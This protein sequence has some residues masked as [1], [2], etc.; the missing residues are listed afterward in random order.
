MKLEQIYRT[1]VE[2]GISKDPRGKEG[3]EQVLEDARKEYEGLKGKEKKRFDRE[4]LENPFP[5]TRILYGDPEMEIASVIAGVDVEAPELLL[6]DRLREKGIRIDLCIAHH[7][8]GRA[9]AGLSEVMSLQADVWADL[10]VPVNIGDALISER[11]AEVRRAFLPQNHQRPVDTARLLDIPFMC[12]HTPA[13][14][15]VTD[16]LS[17]A[18]KR[19]KPRLVVDVI[20]ELLKQPEYEAAA[21]RGLGPTVIAGEARK[22]AGELFVDMT[23]GTELPTSAIEKLADA[24][25]G[26]MICMHMSD[27]LKKEAEKYHINVVVA[28][29]IASDNIGLN[30]LL[31]RLE[32]KG[33]KIHAFS[34]LD[35]VSRLKR[36]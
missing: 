19:A 34:G 23:G 7:P 35:R 1:A 30:L 29:H 25:V 36:K 31:D 22:R 24:G 4:R 15:L 11:M 28:G 32:A 8:E 2:L 10:G 17:R 27:K 26:T 5:D 16:M 21:G 9:L 12:V 14:N 13:D 20:E 18:L 3:V 6:V 33:V